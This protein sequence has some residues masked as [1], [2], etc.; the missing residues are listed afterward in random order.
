MWPFNRKK[1]MKTTF[2]LNEKENIDLIT[3]AIY[4]QNKELV[5]ALAL[6]M[7]TAVINLNIKL[8]P[9]TLTWCIKEKE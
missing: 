9:V 6:G 3:Q 7:K 1:E 2:E 8:H 5:D 4:T